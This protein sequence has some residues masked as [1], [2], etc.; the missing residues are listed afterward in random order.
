M[1]GGTAL[2]ESWEAI[3]RLAIVHSSGTKVVLKLTQ[4]CV[5]LD[6]VGADRRL[7]KIT[8]AFFWKEAPDYLIRDRDG[9]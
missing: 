3:A 9:S 5:D 4:P 6:R 8:D 7:R 2:D 1:V